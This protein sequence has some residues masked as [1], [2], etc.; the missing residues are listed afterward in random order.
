MAG[1][2]LGSQRLRMARVRGK[3]GST[4]E[5]EELLEKVYCRFE[6]ARRNNSGS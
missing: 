5:M 1:C 2:L 6:P 4:S 3:Q